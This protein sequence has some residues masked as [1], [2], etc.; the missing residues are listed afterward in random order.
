MGSQ[1]HPSIDAGTILLTGP[2]RAIASFGT[3]REHSLWMGSP[4]RV[5]G[6]KDKVD[7]LPRTS[8]GLECFDP[9]RS[10]GVTSAVTYAVCF[11]HCLFASYTSLCFHIDSTAA[12]MRL[13]SVNLA[14]LGLIPASNI[15]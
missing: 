7:A 11:R 14:R 15:R 13:A 5:E 3:P 1:P 10:D 9:D 12:A 6:T 8:L 2:L 4:S